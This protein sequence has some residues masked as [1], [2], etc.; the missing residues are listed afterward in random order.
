MKCIE[1]KIT[2]CDSTMDFIHGG[3]RMIREVY[4]KDHDFFFNEDEY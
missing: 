1:Y 3:G 4:C 2:I